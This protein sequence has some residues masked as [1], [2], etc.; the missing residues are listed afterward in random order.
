[1]SKDQQRE[2]HDPITKQRYSYQEVF[3]IAC[4]IMGIY[5]E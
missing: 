2:L 3:E 4:D 1:M 5:P